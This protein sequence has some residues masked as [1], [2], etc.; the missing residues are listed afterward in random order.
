LDIETRRRAGLPHIGMACVQ[1]DVL[2]AMMAIWLDS[3]GIA[4][5]ILFSAEV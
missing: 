2:L 4:I 1:I 5:F 3:A